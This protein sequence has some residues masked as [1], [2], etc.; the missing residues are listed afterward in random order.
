MKNLSGKTAFVTGGGSGIGFGLART[1]LSEGMT[2][3]IADASA[4]R[5]S[6]VREALRGSNAVHLIQVDVSDRAGLAA[7][8]DEAIRHCGKIHLLCN[9][10]GIAGGGA[11]A[12]PD[13]ADWD[14][15]LAV[16]LGGVVN[17]VK[18]IV[19]HIR[20]HGEGG[21]IVNTSSMAGIVPLPD[22]GGAYTTAKFAVRGLTESLRLSLAP[23]GIGVSC[24]CPGLT[25]SRIMQGPEGQGNSLAR[26]GDP[27]ALFN[28]MDG[29]MDPLD[30]GAAVVRGIRENAAYI[31][32]HGEFADEVSTQFADIVAA[33]PTDQDVPA[34]R[35]AFETKRRDMADAR[36]RLP[37]ID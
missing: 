23:E 4:A 19:P 11:V 9:N 36:R 20:A 24:L 29:A 8:A 18:V 15:A 5:L 25:T 21:H 26:E 10:A 7:A 28:S 30:L 16:N 31:L 17:G 14:R 13:F 12:D 37:V 33:F 34:A 22:D 2:V 3:V 35:L 27:D 32:P 1:F 6:E